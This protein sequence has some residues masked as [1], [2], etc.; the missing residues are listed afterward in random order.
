MAPVVVAVHV[1][2]KECLAEVDDKRADRVL[3]IRDSDFGRPS[4]EIS[5]MFHEIVSDRRRNN[6]N[7]NDENGCTFPESG[8]SSKEWDK[9]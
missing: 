1:E 5:G 8:I 7:R 2:H 6:K 4:E 9:E 3:R